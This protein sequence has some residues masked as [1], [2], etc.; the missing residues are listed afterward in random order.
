MGV[1]G[2][3]V[4]LAVGPRGL[5]AVSKAARAWVPRVRDTRFADRNTPRFTV[6]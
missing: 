2:L 4:L 6:E 3:A 5:I 1:P